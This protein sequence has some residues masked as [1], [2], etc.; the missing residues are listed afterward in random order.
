MTE[1]AWQVDPL[2]CSDVRKAVVALEAG[3]H[4]YQHVPSGTHFGNFPGCPY[5]HSIVYGTCKLSSRKFLYGRLV[6]LWCGGRTPGIVRKYC[7][8]ASLAYHRRMRNRP[9]PPEPTKIRQLRESLG[10]SQTQAAE[11]VY[12][13]LRSWQ[14]WEGGQVGMH[15]AIWAWFRHRVESGEAPAF[16]GRRR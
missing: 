10:L 8:Y 1:E 5:S 12:S 3:K 14:N 16:P 6:V 15:P 9:K 2:R 11:L 4:G 7:V 13:T